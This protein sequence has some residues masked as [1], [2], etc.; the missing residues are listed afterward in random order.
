MNRAERRRQER[1]QGRADKKANKK[2]RAIDPCPNGHP[3]QSAALTLYGTPPHPCPRCGKTPQFTAPSGFRSFGASPEFVPSAEPYFGLP[4]R[5]SRQW[6]VEH[7]DKVEGL[8]VV[9]IPVE[10]QDGLVTHARYMVDC[11]HFEDEGDECSCE[12]DE[13]AEW[14]LES[15]EG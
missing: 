12:D 6:I 7:S 2:A 9:P 14:E 10:K 4:K 3:E 15:F 13:A 11:P 8:G 1:E 5:A